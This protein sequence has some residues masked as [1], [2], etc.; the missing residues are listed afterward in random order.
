LLQVVL[1]L[2]VGAVAHKV[3]MVLG[4]AILAGVYGLSFVAS[5]LPVET[6]IPEQIAME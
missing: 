6:S 2:I 3:S 4:F 1:A 5:S